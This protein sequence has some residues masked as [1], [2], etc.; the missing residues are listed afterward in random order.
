MCRID[1]A[2][3]PVLVYMW[4]LQP[5]NVY[6]GAWGQELPLSQAVSSDRLMLLSS[7]ES[8]AFRTAAGAT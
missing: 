4:D 2:A 5:T 7:N 1:E 8:I 6:I 3:G